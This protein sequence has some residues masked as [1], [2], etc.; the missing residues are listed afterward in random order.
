MD[1]DEEALRT[2]LK[3]LRHKVKEVECEIARKQSKRESNCDH[4]LERVF[5]SGPRDNNERYYVCT[6][7]GY[8]M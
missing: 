5:I 1:K 7:C 8:Q 2:E 6:K 4:N 3:S